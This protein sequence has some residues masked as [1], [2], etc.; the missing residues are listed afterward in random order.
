MTQEDDHL[1]WLSRTKLFAG[2]RPPVTSVVPRR[3]G[4][5]LSFVMLS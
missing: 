2:L 3:R 4:L 1:A 5:R